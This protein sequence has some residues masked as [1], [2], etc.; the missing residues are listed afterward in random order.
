MLGLIAASLFLFMYLRR[1]GYGVPASL[2]GLAA[3][4]ASGAVGEVV[5]Y[6][7]LVEPLTVALEVAFLL[8]LQTGAGTLSLACVGLL[9]TLSKEFFLL[10]LPLVY[11]VRRSR[12][13]DGRALRQALLV[14]APCLLGAWLL[15]SGEGLP[16]DVFEG[17]LADLPARL[18][19]D[20]PEDGAFLLV[21][22]GAAIFGD[23]IFGG[24]LRQ[25]VGQPDGEIERERFRRWLVRR[26]VRGLPGPR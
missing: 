9:G 23:A 8:A 22:L 21:L 17:A 26:M 10:L 16:D 1:L 5:R 12:D 15:L 7:F 24:R 13:G 18:S 11:L 6:Q 20:D 25:A 2:L 3:F 4:G 14:S 19:A